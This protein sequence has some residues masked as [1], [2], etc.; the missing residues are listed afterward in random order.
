MLNIGT[1]LIGMSSFLALIS[2]FL[3]AQD[4]VS[5]K[6]KP[7]RTTR[8]TILLTT[9]LTLLSLLAQKDTVAVWLAMASTFQAVMVFGLSLKYGMG[10]WSRTDLLCLGLALTGIVLWK[11]TQNPVLALYAAIAADLIGMLPTLIK[12][13]HFPTTETLRFYLLDTMAA[14]F[15]LLAIQTWNIQHFSYPLYLLLVNLTMVIL[16]FYPR[17]NRTQKHFS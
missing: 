11:T 9:S 16:I 3:Y 13:F 2:P 14:F 15:S 17:L 10:G 5:G 7:H 1:S 4:I 6:A 8:L 12:T